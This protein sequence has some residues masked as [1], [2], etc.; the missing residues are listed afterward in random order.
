[1]HVYRIISLSFAALIVSAAPAAVSAALSAC[2]LSRLIADVVF[3]SESLNGYKSVSSRKIESA[4]F[5]GG[6][7]LNDYLV[8]DIYNVLNLFGALDVKMTYV[9]KTLFAGSYFDKSAEAH[10]ACYNALVDSADF[11]I[12]CDSLDYAQRLFRICEIGRSN[13]Y[14]AVIV[15]INL[16][17]A[18]CANFLDNLTLLA[19]NITDLFGIDLCCEHLGSI[20]RK[21]LAR[22]GNAGKNNLVDYLAACLICF[23]KS[24]FNDFGSKTVNLGVLNCGDTLLRAADL[25]VH[26]AEEILKSL[27]VDHC[28]KAV[29]LGDESA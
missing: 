4:L 2:G 10:K 20:L 25:K 18:L 24:L 8:A 3:G 7:N 28:H 5:I 21:L 12:L 14:G 19:D 26:V 17:V 9:D 27:N 13:K 1:M 11:G 6:K 16:T 15:N 22:G 29:A 23:F